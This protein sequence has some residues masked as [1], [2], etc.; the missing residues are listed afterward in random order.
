MIRGACRTVLV[1]FAIWLMQSTEAAPPALATI[2]LSPLV[3]NL[4]GALEAN[5]VFVSDSTLAL[6]V[7]P[8]PPATGPS[9]I[10]TVRWATGKVLA[11]VTAKET[12]HLHDLYAVSGQ[13]VIVEGVHKVYLYERDLK[14]RVEIPIRVLIP[15]FPLCNAVGDAESGHWRVYRLTPALTLTKS[16]PGEL[17][18][19]SNEYIVSRVGDEV[20]IETHEGRALGNF[21]VDPSTRQTPVVE[22]AGASRLYLR[23]PREDHMAT[24]GG[25]PLLTLRAPDG[26]GFRHGWS[27]DGCRILYDHYVRTVSL[28][29]RAA[30]K[31]LSAVTFGLGAPDESPNGEIVRVVDTTNGAICFDLDSRERLFGLQ[32]QYHADLSPSGRY[33]A[34][35]TQKKLYIYQLPEVCAAK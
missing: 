2:E 19:L 4:G 24:L 13:C 7:H 8:L 26:W 27:A 11:S 18:S 16:G 33:A 31:F 29:R 20:L 23:N 14:S 25:R 6:L 32:G 9:T 30:E 22:V 12:D 17:E 10:V 35:A 34:V 5:P 1:C 21:Q 28:L 15:G 3:S